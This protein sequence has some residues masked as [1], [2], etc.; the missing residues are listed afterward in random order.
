MLAKRKE[1]SSCEDVTTHFTAQAQVVGINHSASCNSH[2][3][4]PIKAKRI[5]NDE[6]FEMLDVI[7]PWDLEAFETNLD[8]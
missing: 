3:F 8:W 5:P 6:E 1:G 7:M 4:L 2:M